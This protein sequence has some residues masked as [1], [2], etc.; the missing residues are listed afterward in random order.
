MDY[1]DREAAPPPETENRA[2]VEAR[3]P[4][5]SA[6]VGSDETGNKAKTQG[7]QDM[8][9][10]VL[11]DDATMTRVI[12]DRLPSETRVWIDQQVWGLPNA[13]KTFLGRGSNAALRYAEDL[14]AELV[15]RA[16]SRTSYRAGSKARNAAGR[17]M[18]R[19]ICRGGAQ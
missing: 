5:S 1:Q 15:A 2:P 8:R 12:I 19:M 7:P 3:F 10:S 13:A 11:R 6:L 4:V 18:A 16:A 17:E 9:R 14:L